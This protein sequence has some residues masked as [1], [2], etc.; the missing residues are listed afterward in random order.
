MLFGIT[1]N[2]LDDPKGPEHGLHNDAV[3]VRLFRV[4]TR[5]L[6]PSA[7]K[8]N[9]FWKNDSLVKAMESH[10]IFYCIEN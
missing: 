1:Q 2:K 9:G 4:T 5:H 8:I 3:G 10:K 7:V 6:T